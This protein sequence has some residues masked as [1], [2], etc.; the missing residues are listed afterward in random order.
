MN[1][2]KAS[3]L[4]LRLLINKQNQSNLI[5]LKINSFYDLLNLEVNN[6]VEVCHL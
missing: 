4:K 1:D 2:E 5:G 6:S 3:L